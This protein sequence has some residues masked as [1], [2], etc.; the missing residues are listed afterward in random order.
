M[1]ILAEPP[2]NQQCCKCNAQGRHSVQHD[3]KVFHVCEA[4][5]PSQLSILKA[6]GHIANLKGKDYVLYA[7]LLD[8]AH[9]NGL[10]SMKCEILELDSDAKFCLIKA[11]VS[12]TRGT[13]VAHGDANPENTGKMV[14]SAFIR[15]AETRAYARCLRLYCGVGMTCREELPPQA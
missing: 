3:D 13:F 6:N 11:T 5:R 9:R 15:M 14:L 12:G 10:Q 8:M 4:H 7:G 2:K 1:R